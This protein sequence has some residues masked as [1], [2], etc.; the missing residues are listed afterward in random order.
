MIPL[1]SHSISNIYIT[2]HNSGKIAVMKLQQNN[3][4]VGGHK[5]MKNRVKES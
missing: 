3:S 2:I 5:N 4:I 1:Q